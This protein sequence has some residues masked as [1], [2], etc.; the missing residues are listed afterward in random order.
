[1]SENEILVRKVIRLETHMNQIKADSIAF[2]IFAM[3]AYLF[4]LW[5]CVIHPIPVVVAWWEYRKMANITTV[6]SLWTHM[7]GT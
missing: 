3:F 5:V 1:M 2:G 7:M 6:A 4:L